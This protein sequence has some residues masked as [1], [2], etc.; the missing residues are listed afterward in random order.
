MLPP[1]KLASIVADPQ[2][3]TFPDAMQPLGLV[4]A[5]VEVTPIHNGDRYTV[6]PHEDHIAKSAHALLRQMGICSPRAPV[7]SWCGRDVLGL[8]ADGDRVP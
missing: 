4:F 8:P 2:T 6:S 7:P 1:E 5:N 3:S